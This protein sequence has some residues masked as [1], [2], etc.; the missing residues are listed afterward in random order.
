MTALDKKEV[1]HRV[2]V[3]KRLK[4]LLLG[5]REKFRTYLDIL[6]HQ[7]N[8]IAD[9]D[10]ERLHEHV[11]FEQAIVSEIYSFQKAIDPLEDMYRMAYPERE[12]ET[13]IPALRESLERIR[14]EVLVRNE[15]NQE[16][17][18]KGMGELRQK[19]KGLR[20]VRKLTSVLPVEPR[21]TLID[22]TA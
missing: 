6:E 7:E 19:I 18:R 16:L 10:T 9:G 21:P 14:E 4:D 20:S 13:E 3:L 5:Q 22:T 8:D 1:E 15:H 12:E 11:E 17:L 2:A